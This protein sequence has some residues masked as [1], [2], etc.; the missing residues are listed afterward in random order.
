MANF[1]RSNNNIKAMRL[2]GQRKHGL[3][4]RR[5]KRCWGGNARLVNE[6]RNSRVISLG[7]EKRRVRHLT[8][9]PGGAPGERKL[10]GAKL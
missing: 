3:G 6:K 8:K 2:F 1:F 9:R 10:I 4:G 5:L 7:W